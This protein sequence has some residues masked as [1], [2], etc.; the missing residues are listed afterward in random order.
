MPHLCQQ[1]PSTWKKPLCEDC[2]LRIIRGEQATFLMEMGTVVRE[3]V[4][5]SVSAWLSTQ[6]V[7]RSQSKRPRWESDQSSEKEIRG[8]DSEE[9]G[10]ITSEPPETGK[11]YLFTSEN[12]DELL[13]AVRST[14]QIEEAPKE[15]SI[16][17]VMFGG[18]RA[19]VR[20]VFP[21]N[22]H[23]RAMILEEWEDAEKRLI[24]PRDFKLRLPFNPEGINTWDEVPKI[25]SQVARV[26]RKTSIPFEDSSSLK[27]PMDKKADVLLKRAW[28]ASAA[29]IKA[30]IAATSVARSMHLWIDQMEQQLEE[31]TPRGDILESIPLLKIATGFLADASAESVR[32]AARNNY[33]TR[34][35]E[36]YGL[37]PGRGTT[38]LA[39][40]YVPYLSRGGK[41]F[42]PALDKILES[43]SDDKRGFP[44]EKPRKQF[45]FQRF[46]PYQRQEYLCFLLFVFSG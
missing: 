2:T 22:D 28:E 31:K 8:S 42:G 18:L 24:V 43:A 14:M 1:A 26:S 30:N 6:S 21:V 9:E 16:Q 3:E 23:I 32:F 38:S 11:K 44:E 12:T 20:Q 37:K 15:Q 39:I 34:P 25:D 33:P 17:D 10:E 29:V 27:E 19:R 7:D 36:P 5:A 45:S 40:N 46:R 35:V 13:S 4:Q 41:V